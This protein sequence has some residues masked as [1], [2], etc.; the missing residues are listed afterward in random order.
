MGDEL[1]H[2]VAAFVDRHDLWPAGDRMLALVSGG[3]DSICLMHL[4]A[5]L[6]PAAL[7]VLT[8]DHGLRHEAAREADA[9][10][11][12]ATR[13]GLAVWVERLA[14]APGPGLQERARDGRL[15][16]ARRI[17]QAHGFDRVATG[18]T[19]DDQAETVLFRLARGTG[20]TGAV[21]MAPVAGDL[22]AL[23]HLGR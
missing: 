15:A 18:H 3:A 21:G 19:A 9:V 8:V 1:A 2:R 7:G 10:V 20:R 6:R 23:G 12:A 16:A 5:G 14:L 13:L 11:D 4:L 17:A 22:A